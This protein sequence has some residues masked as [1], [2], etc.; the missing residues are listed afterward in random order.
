MARR[1]LTAEWRNLAML[2]YVVDPALLVPFVPKGTVLDTWND[3]T[4]VSLVGFMF[5]DT[6]VLG[7]PIPFHRT[8]EEVNLRFYVSR[9]VDGEKRRA[10]TF[11]REL[12]PRRAIALAARLGYNEPYTALPMR[13]N[14]VVPTGARSA[15]DLVPTGARSATEG[16]ALQTVKYEWNLA[17]KWCGIHLETTGAPRTIEPGSEEEFITE[18]YWGYTRQRDGSTVEYQV[19]H[20]PW[21]VSA[22]SRSAVVGDL[23]ELYG[24]AFAAKL[25]E[26]PDSAFLA[27]GSAIS[28]S[29]PRHLLSD[30]L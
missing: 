13:H 28:V 24:R 19:V 1:F 23:T 16:P 9:A 10:V 17:G 2:N 7:V 22:V 5:F 20:S 18:H 14:I 27:D 8:F 11:L 12:V 25:A 6:K 15:G 3:R 29:L 30:E 26:P 4:Y 21:K